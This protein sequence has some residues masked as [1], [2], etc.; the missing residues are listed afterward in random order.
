MLTT[1]KATNLYFTEALAVYLAQRLD[2]IERLVQRIEAGERSAGSGRREPIVARIELGRTTRHH[3]KGSVYRAEVT[4]D[5]PRRAPL[6]AE[7]EAEDIRLAIDLVRK[8]VSREIRS[9]KERKQAL[10][11]KGGREMKRRIRGA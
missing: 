10:T 7:A 3:R 11:R 6:R 5:I 4:L 8:E 2:A 1:V 9:W